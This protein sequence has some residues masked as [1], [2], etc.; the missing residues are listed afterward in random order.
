MAE[1]RRLEAAYSVANY[2]AMG[3]LAAVLVVGLVDAEL[4]F[5]PSVTRTRPRAVSEAP[6][7]STPSA[8]LSLGFGSA[9]FRLRF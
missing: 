3:V 9:I 8:T 2:L 1:V 5:V 6:Q 7:P 4:R